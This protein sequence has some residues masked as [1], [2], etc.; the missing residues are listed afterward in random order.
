MNADEVSTGQGREA[1]SEAPA[2]APVV[3]QAII[4]RSRKAAD[5]AAQEAAEDDAEAAVATA[6]KPKRVD[7]PKPSRIERWGMNPEDRARVMEACLLLQRARWKTH[8]SLMMVMAVIVAIMGL[9]A[10]SA[11]LVIG[12]ML[13]APLMTPVLGIAAAIAMAL[14]PALMRSII[15]VVLA[16]VGAIGMGWIAGAL[17][18]GNEL[19]DQMLARTQPDLRDLI[20]AVAAGIAG[21][22]ATARPDVSSSLPGVA[23]AVALVPPLAVVGLTLQAGE[24][25]LAG[26]ALLLYI[27]NLSA[28]I[29]VSTVVFVMA[30]FVPARRLAEMSPRVILG[31]LVALAV[32]IGASV[33][34]G[35]QSFSIAERN[36]LE[37]EVASTIDEWLIGTPGLELEDFNVDG[38]DVRVEVVGPDLN[39]A[40]I[41]DLDASLAPV[42]GVE[43]NVDLRWTQASRPGTAATPT[44]D[45][46]Q[47]TAIR[48]VVLQWLAGGGE[49][50]DY[51]LTSLGLSGEDGIRIGVSSADPVPS[52]DD[53]ALRLEDQLGI[54]PQLQIDWTQRT[55]IVP[56]TDVS[57]VETQL[58]ELRIVAQDWAAANNVALEDIAFDGETIEVETIGEQQPPIVPLED[59]LLERLDA[60]TQANVSVR[61]YF[62]Q[63]T[64]VVADRPPTPT[65]T[66]PPWWN[67]DPGG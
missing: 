28:I 53:L 4:D 56:G 29:A 44:S 8:F 60:Q 30:G 63:R 51:E 59:G 13:I 27:T 40:A 23:I 65:P 61:V 58:G 2:N 9:S 57:T 22:Y 1:G 41:T 3:P 48:N 34:L 47:R 35:R 10:N 36:S 38:A 14:G 16:T 42:L 50:D 19:T 12:A 33:L 49:G 11:A 55:R 46:L 20:V 17:L 39:P 43:P 21:S 64:L 32:L 25:G 45:E 26:G 24:P 5:K 15:T 52:L 18:P 7:L 67:P 66:P 62:T 37:K 54:S 31:A 6:D